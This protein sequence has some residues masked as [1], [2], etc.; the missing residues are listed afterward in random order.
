MIHA[1]SV[2]SWEPETTAENQIIAQQAEI[3]ELQAHKHENALLRAE[4]ERLKAE[5][6]HWEQASHN[7][8]NDDDVETERLR[9]ENKLLRDIAGPVAVTELPF[10]GQHLDWI[11]FVT[12][13][14]EIH[15]RRREAILSPLTTGNSV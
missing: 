7:H 5:R 12:V 2:R 6:D 15:K 13:W 1:D 10:I 4:V 11:A 8:A 9:A 3:K 14:D